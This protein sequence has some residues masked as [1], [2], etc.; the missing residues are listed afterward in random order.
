[1]S[2]SQLL[3]EGRRTKTDHKGSPCH[4][5]TGELQKALFRLHGEQTGLYLFY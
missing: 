3:T 4:Y 2:F 1:M 5:V